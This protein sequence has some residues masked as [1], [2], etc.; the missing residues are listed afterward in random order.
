MGRLDSSLDVLVGEDLAEEVTDG[1]VVIAV[2]LGGP[3]ATSVAGD[4]CLD[5][6]RGLVIGCG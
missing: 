5:H 2:E 1:G 6:V 3:G 4:G